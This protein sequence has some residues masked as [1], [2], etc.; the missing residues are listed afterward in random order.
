MM[1]A[2]HANITGQ[3]G[4]NSPGSVQASHPMRDDCGVD[5]RCEGLLGDRSPLK[6]KTTK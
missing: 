5:T 2:F 6:K 4:Q 3:G 1:V